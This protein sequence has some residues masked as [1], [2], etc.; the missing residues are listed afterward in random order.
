MREAEEAFKRGAA[1]EAYEKARQA[2]EVNP[3]QRSARAILRKVEE[4]RVKAESAS[5]QL[6]AALKKPI[7]IELRDA[8]VRSVFELISKR[9]GLN[10]VY[11]RDVPPDAARHGV[12]ARHLASRKCCASCW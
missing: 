5:P 1:D 4:Q 2:L 10:F 11:D 8:P 3:T 7:T 12:R 6:T 9:S